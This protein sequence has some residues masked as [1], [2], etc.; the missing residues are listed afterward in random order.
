MKK[1]VCSCCKRKLTLDNFHRCSAQKDGYITICKEC[2]KE[3][4]SKGGKG[5]ETYRKYQNKYQNKFYHE[6][7]NEK[8]FKQ[9]LKKYRKEFNEQ[10]PNYYKKYNKNEIY[11][12]IYIYIFM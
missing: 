2:R 5:Y 8:W 10:H 6:H 11:Y 4:V 12:F 7:K 1:K 9:K 3:Y